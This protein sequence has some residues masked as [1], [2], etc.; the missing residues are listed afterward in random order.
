M[1]TPATAYDEEEEEV[2]ESTPQRSPLKRVPRISVV[3]PEPAPPQPAT[4]ST[5]GM[6]PQQGPL[7]SEGFAPKAPLVFSQ[8]PVARRQ[9]IVEEAT[10]RK[11]ERFDKERPFAPSGEFRGLTNHEGRV[12]ERMGEDTYRTQVQSKVEQMRAERAATVEAQRG[13]NA[14]REQTFRGSGQQFYTDPYGD[15]QPVIEEGTGRALYQ[16]SDWEDGGVHP[17]TGEPTMRR[18]DKYGQQQFKAPQITTG[19]DPMDDQLYYKFSDTDLRPAGSVMELVNHANP[20]IAKMAQAQN[21]KRMQLGRIQALD[22]QAS[23]VAQAEL[24]VNAAQDE[25]NRLEGEI[26]N[27]RM[28]AQTDPNAA[29][30]VG[31][32]RMAQR[33]VEKQMKG[34]LARGVTGAKN[35]FELARATAKRDQYA[36]QEE[37]RMGIV[38]AQGG[39]VETDPILTEIRKQRG[40]YE[41]QVQAFANQQAKFA[42]LFQKKEQQ[43]IAE[44]PVST[45][46]GIGASAVR[47][48]RQ[49]LAAMDVLGAQNRQSKGADYAAQADKLEQQAASIDTLQPNWSPENRRAWAERALTTAAQLRE[50]AGGMQESAGGQLQGAAEQLKKAGGIRSSK[51]YEDYQ[52]ATG[53]E[54]L[55][56]FFKN[57]VEIA[58]NIA[59]EGAAGSIP[60]IAAGAVGAATAGPAGLAAGTGIGS[61]ATEYASTLLETMSEAG[62]D[63]GNVR[64]M[65]QAMADPQIM[66]LARTKGLARGIPIAAFDALSGGLAGRVVGP[67]VRGGAGIVKAGARELGEQAGAGM[68][69]ELAGQVSEQ[70][71]TTGT[72]SDISVKDVMAEGLG[73]AVPGSAQIAMGAVGRAPKP[74]VTPP[75]TGGNPI[76]APD[77]PVAPTETP[78]QPPTTAQDQPDLAE[79]LGTPANA[80]DQPAPPITAPKLT[81]EQEARLEVLA[82]LAS[83]ELTTEE[84]AAEEARLQEIFAAPNEAQT[85]APAPPVTPAVVSP[86]AD[87]VV[88]VTPTP[89]AS[90]QPTTAQGAP[91]AQEVAQG[92]GTQETDTRVAVP[93]GQQ[94]KVERPEQMAARLSAEAPPEQ[95]A[96]DLARYDEL[97]RTIGEMA[98][99]GKGG[100]DA[101]V[102]KIWKENE[103]IKNRYG[104]MPPVAPNIPV[105]LPEP[106][107]EPGRGGEDVRRPG[108]DIGEQPPQK[109]LRQNYA[110]AAEF[111]EAVK[112]YKS[113]PTPANAIQEPSA[114]P[115]PVKPAAESREGLRQGNVGQQA[116]VREAAPVE[117]HPEAGEVKPPAQMKR[118]ELRAEL[119]AAG[120]KSV[121]GV[122]LDEANAAQLMNAVGKLRRGQ[123]DEPK[124]DIIER[125]KAKKK[126]IDPNK[127]YSG[128]DPEGAYNVAYNAAIDIAIIAIR[129]GRT[130]QQAVQY[131]RRRLKE[132]FP[133]ATPEQEAKLE[134]DIM[135]AHGGEPPTTPTKGTAPDE[136]AQNPTPSGQ[137]F[138]GPV[139]P[140]DKAFRKRSKSALGEYEYVSTTN[141]GQRKYAAEFANWHDANSDYESAVAEMRSIDEPAFRSVVAGEL[142][143][144]QMEKYVNAS[145]AEQ[146]AIAPRLASLMGDVKSG[147]TEPAQA[148]QAQVVVN[149]RLRPFAHLLAWH[150]LLRQRI[151][152]EVPDKA[153]PAVKGGIKKAND[154]AVDALK[155]AIELPDGDAPKG[156]NAKSI[157]EWLKKHASTLTLLRKAAKSRGM[158]WADIFNDLPENQ[159]ARKTELFER[160]QKHEKLQN[161]NDG[162]K[163]RLAENLDEAWTYLRNQIFRNEFGRLVELPNV[164][165]KDAEKI[166]SVV[167]ELIKYSNLGLLDNDAFLNAM[168][169]KYGME[170]MDGPTAKKLADI[171]ARIQRAKSPAEKAKLEMDMLQAFHLARGVNPVDL[172]TS[173]LY[174]NTLFAYTTQLMA[175]LGGNIQNTI[176]QLGTM[177]LVNPKK[178]GKLAKGYVG[179]MPEAWRQA[180]SIF[181]TGHGGQDAAAM[182]AEGR[183]DALE[184][185][186][187]NSVYPQLEK[188]LPVV[189]K[190]LRGAAQTAK[191]V[192]RFMR[193]V[194]ALAFYPAKEAYT[195]VAMENILEG[196]YQGKELADRVRDLLSIKPGD[197]LAAKQQAEREGFRDHDLARRMSDIIEE[198]RSST[199]EG[200]E[201]VEAG[202]RFGESTTLSG[203]PTGWAGV[204][205]KRAAQFT[206]EFRPGGIP[207]AKPFLMFLR[208]PTNFY[209]RAIG[210]TPFGAVQASNIGPS[211]AAF[212]RALWKGGS[213]S[214]A[215]QAFGEKLNQAETIT[216]N[217]KD[218][219]FVRQKLTADERNQ[220]YVQSLIGTSLMAY[221]TIKALSGKPDDDDTFDLTASGPKSSTKRAQWRDAGNIPYSMRVPGTKTRINFQNSPLAIP[222]AIAGHITDSARYEETSDELIGNAVT[223]AMVRFPSVI[224]GAPVMQGLSELAELTDA[225]GGNAEKTERFLKNLGKNMVMPRIIPQIAQLFDPASEKEGEP[226]FDS[227]GEPV[228]W[229]PHDRFFS[230]ETDDPLRRWLQK[231]E[232][233]VPRVGRDTKV[234]DGFGIKT[235]KMEPAEYSEYTRKAGLMTRMALQA[236]LPSLRT[237]TQEEAQKEVTRIANKEHDAIL[238]DVREMAEL[239]PAKK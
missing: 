135:Q 106:G 208:V 191:F 220:L 26:G 104:G 147:K 12:A 162:Q 68:A 235:R 213:T 61:F 117:A 214:D 166:K 112:A 203:E 32:L 177:A 97:N 105:R 129:A 160:I 46:G 187:K 55:L 165:P 163:K 155:A 124:P 111:R 113:Q 150:D 90:Q 5:G 33:E 239:K 232:I 82:S 65:A 66:E 18:R 210:Y 51:V 1:P 217:K 183:G 70:L 122:S 211:G 212:A 47:A 49:S 182:M 188:N 195:R 140:G 161:L 199:A 142:L 121:S 58:S 137:T 91:P 28:I 60:T 207:L 108:V 205:Y 24:Q 36:E 17:K 30:Q 19:S 34:P 120:V 236:E 198:R 8:D 41:A 172:A 238:K 109:P 132:K 125:L 215:W 206:D 81:D 10:R 13:R 175:N 224:L 27:L 98:R 11:K 118:P 200:R 2:Y 74:G 72:V 228:T 110:T 144:R 25:F 42:E 170:N 88:P 223:N 149:E 15:I 85:P 31:Q 84:R 156:K 216:T 96:Q 39:N 83:A 29:A 128:V 87:A 237:M 3:T 114:A 131:A 176:T 209:N 37:E 76:G 190:G 222:L 226:Q 95:L 59:A 23:A 218:G 21:R 154:E 171:A 192:S 204:A 48:G 107:T 86:P 40:I 94:T 67:A 77:R 123:L 73:E 189:A 127:L 57:P 20:R 141:D 126:K 158:K 54:A 167:G 164:K 116:P 101:E 119:S 99:A 184:I 168:A 152:K 153:F 71:A 136:P 92:T 231:S 157:E 44:Q 7:G 169:E 80:G 148:L 78:G 64:E 43:E 230:Q 180:A 138:T 185:V 38:Q 178:A 9:Q 227:L 35:Q 4:G 45:L 151:A 197:Y 14:A 89:D 53:A 130:V 173:F 159:E 233:T 194:D 174:A 115:L 139:N 75:D 202:K 133:N 234:P 56:Q 6:L 69:G 229:R 143:A 50:R 193:S 16:Q 219:Q 22:G 225:H 146:Q 52:K 201:A 100:D 186:A 145:A 79:A 103:Q 62:I 179:G 221:F 102:A 181:M 93:E 134:K 63:M 196:K